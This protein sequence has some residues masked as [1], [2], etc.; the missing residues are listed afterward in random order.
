LLSS[1]RRVA[2]S[3]LAEVERIVRDN[4]DSR[5]TLATVKRDELMQLVK[6]GTASVIDVRPARNM[7]RVI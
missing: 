3:Q 6:M 7:R 5:D 2:E 1:I 4:F